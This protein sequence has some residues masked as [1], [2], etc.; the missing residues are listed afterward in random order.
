M[1]S[2]RLFSPFFELLI[3]SRNLLWTFIAHCHATYPFVLILDAYFVTSGAPCVTFH[4]ILF[5]RLQAFLEIFRKCHHIGNPHIRLSESVGLVFLFP[6]PTPAHT[7]LVSFHPVFHYTRA[8]YTCIIL[9]VLL[10]RK[11]QHIGNLRSCSSESV[12]LVFS[13]PSIPPFLSHSILFFSLYTCKPFPEVFLWAFTL[14]IHMSGC[15]YTFRERGP[16]TA[17]VL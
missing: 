12:V 16:T 6:L 8:L 1:Y 2:P 17:L 3:F 5:A 15:L 7:L 14:P 13:S 10:F 4:S 11:R 9:F